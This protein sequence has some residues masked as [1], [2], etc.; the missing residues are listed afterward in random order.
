LTGV[1]LIVVLTHHKIRRLQGDPDL[2]RRRSAAARARR[3]FR[4]A[5]AADC[6]VAER[7]DRKQ[8]ALFGLVAAAAGIPEAGLTTDDVR[9]QLGRLG[10]E[11]PLND[12]LRLWCEACDA[13]RYGATTDVAGELDRQAETVLDQLIR[14]L[15][16]KKLIR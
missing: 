4:E 11:E 6:T 14:N 8:A 13:V 12:R 1:Y 15:K 5:A 10:I 16:A 3:R 2:G 7:A 9:G